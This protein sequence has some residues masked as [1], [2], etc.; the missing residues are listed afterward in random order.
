[1]YIQNAETCVLTRPS[2][3]MLHNPKA[4][5]RQH[6]K[7]QPSPIQH[8]LHTNTYNPVSRMLRTRLFTYLSN[9][10]TRATMQLAGGLSPLQTRIPGRP[11]ASLSNCIPLDANSEIQRL[12]RTPGLGFVYIYIYIYIV[13]IRIYIY[14]CVRVCAFSGFLATYVFEPQ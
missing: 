6:S 8:L 4:S 11:L 14:K 5:N 12:G 13:L 9:Q 1:M 10:P 2:T 7:T 3:P